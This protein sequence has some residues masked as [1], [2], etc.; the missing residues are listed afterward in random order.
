MTVKHTMTL[1][2]DQAHLL[3]RWAEKELESPTAVAAAW[4]LKGLID[5]HLL[6]WAQNKWHHDREGEM[7]EVIANAPT[8][9]EE[10]EREERARAHSERVRENERISME[11]WEIQ[12][13]CRKLGNKRMEVYKNGPTVEME[14]FALAWYWSDS[15]SA[16][17]T[18]LTRDWDMPDEATQGGSSDE[19]DET[20]PK[21]TGR[22]ACT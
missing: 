17:W 20:R 5:A 15:P 8:V 12:S 13:A 6:E 9:E 10:N 22:R 18:R 11:K 4:V 14:D 19:E 3:H 7:D 21:A 16:I 2:D 1:T